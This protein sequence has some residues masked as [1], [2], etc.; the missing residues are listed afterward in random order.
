MTLQS[1]TLSRRRWNGEEEADGEKQTLD[2]SKHSLRIVHRQ[3]LLQVRMSGQQMTTEFVFR[4]PPLIDFKMSVVSV[5]ENV[6]EH[7]S[8]NIQADRGSFTMGSPN[9]ELKH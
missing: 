8:T 6:I 7:G 2:E 4:A 5:P 1:I 3:V 9:K